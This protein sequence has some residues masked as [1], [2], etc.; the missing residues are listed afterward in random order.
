MTQKWNLQD[1]KPAQSRRKREPVLENSVP[2]DNQP[3]GATAELHEDVRTSSVNTNSR[4]RTKQR[5]SVIVA[6]V[7]VVVIGG[8]F[9][10]SL[11]MSGAELV[12]YPRFK[13]PNVN[14]VFTASLNKT[15]NQPAYEIMVLEAEGE[16]Q[17]QAT[18]KEVVSTQAEGSI[19]IY[20]NHQNQ[21]VRLVTNTRFEAPGGLIFRIK[22]SVVIPGYSLNEAGEKVPGSVSAEVFAD[23]TGLNYNI[24]PTRLTIPGFAGE[25]EFDNLYAESTQTFAGG[26]EGERFIIPDTELQLARQALHTE[27]RNALLERIDTEK[28]ADFITFSDAV[29][30]TY[31]SLPSLAY[32]DNLATIKERV[33][34][35]IPLF[36]ANDFA[37][38]IAS[39]T[40]P[41]FEAAAV[42]ITDPNILKFS[43]TSTTTAVSNISE[44][45]SIEF[46]IEG[47][48]QI[49]W[50]YDEENLKTDLLDKNRTALTSVLGAYPAIDKAEATIRPFWSN[51][52]P[53][54][55]SKIEIVEIIGV[56]E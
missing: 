42:R 40:V 11:L 15:E 44:Q 43:Y 54:D 30:F 16:R 23:E 50:E 3:R 39:A 12:V 2:M 52:F 4:T 27:L 10:G 31:T 6:I 55:I 1:I 8:G 47:R 17:V 24:E 29:T 35:R 14:A 48:P 38:F 45:D 25:P 13:E 20:N 36:A 46:K 41:N 7:F 53:A 19:I 9:I 5:S 18:G 34:L 37:A 33:Y 28:P 51:G 22:D 32:D 56:P 21:T 26:F 49:V